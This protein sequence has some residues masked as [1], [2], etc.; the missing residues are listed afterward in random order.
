MPMTSHVLGFA[1]LL[2]AAMAGLGSVIRI[3]QNR[4]LYKWHRKVHEEKKRKKRG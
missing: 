4:R 2:F 1:T 3:L